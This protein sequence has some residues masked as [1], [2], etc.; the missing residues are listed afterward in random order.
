MKSNEELGEL[1][2]ILK[3]YGFLSKATPLSVDDLAK[4]LCDIAH[5]EGYQLT[6]KLEKLK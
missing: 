4:Y 6:Y 1:N 5:N 2:N 3:T